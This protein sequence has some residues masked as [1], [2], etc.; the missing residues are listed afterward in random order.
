MQNSKCK[1]IA[2]NA[3]ILVGSQNT[4]K[5]STL[6]SLTGCFN[7]SIRDI[8]LY[9]GK[10]ISVY[11]RVASLQESRTSPIDYINE[12]TKTGCV[13][14]IFCLWPTANQINTKLY[15][16]ASA[17]ILAF[18]IAGWK[19][20]AVAILGSSTF[21]PLNK[22]HYNFPNSTSAPINST[23]SDVREYFRWQ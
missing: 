11:A 19:I 18:K 17:Y 16:D 13:N 23:A 12:A 9:N 1:G 3:Y 14:T 20:S 5:S 8:L 22:R 15:P 21:T 4:R 2:L 7:R 6:R 10:T